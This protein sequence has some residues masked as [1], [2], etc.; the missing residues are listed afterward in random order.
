MRNSFS[1][2]L[3]KSQVCGEGVARGGHERKVVSIIG[4]VRKP[5]HLVRTV[6]VDLARKLDAGLFHAH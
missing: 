4:G 5:P 2:K 6:D 1:R 3:K